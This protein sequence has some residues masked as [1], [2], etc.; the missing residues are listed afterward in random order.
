MARAKLGEPNAAIS[1]FDIAIRLKPDLT[2]G[3]YNRGVAKYSLGQLNAAISDFDIAIRL[4][5]DDAY[6]YYY[7]GLAKA[8]LNRTSEAKQDLRTALRLV[9]KARDIRL[10]AS[11][12]KA[13]RL[14]N[15]KH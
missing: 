6:A 12:E 8:M 5:P 1:D 7:R 13:L 14:L 11:V 10:K 9:E 4:K 3:Y 2:D 15:R